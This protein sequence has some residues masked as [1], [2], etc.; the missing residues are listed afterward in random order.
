MHTIMTMAGALSVT[1]I[2]PYVG[3]SVRSVHPSM[4]TKCGS[5]GGDRGSGPLLEN[6]KLWVSIENKLKKK[7]LS[8]LFFVRLTWT[9]H[10][11]NS[12]IHACI[13]HINDIRSLS[14]IVLIRML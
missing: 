6:H 4:H 8:E 5:R 3:S 10:D 11:E 2:H 13:R 9:P 1:L 7:M 14:L 12:W